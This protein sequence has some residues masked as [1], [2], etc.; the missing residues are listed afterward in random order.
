MGG[1]TYKLFEKMSGIARGTKS[2]LTFPKN[3]AAI[4]TIINKPTYYPDM[5]RK[6]MWEMWKENFV[7]LLKHKELNRFYTSYGLD[8]KEFRDP[9]DFIAHQE[10]CVMRDMGNQAQKHTIT[11]RY[12]YIVLLRDKYA[13][14]SYLASTIG[15]QFIVKSVALIT[16][17]NAFV[18]DTKSWIAPETLLSDGSELVFKVLDG[19]CADGVM[20]VQAKD[21]AVVV[22]GH[23]YTKPEFIQ[24]ISGKNI[25]VQNVVAQHSALKAFKT[26]SVNTIRIVTIKGTSGAVNVFAAFLRLSASPNSFVD[27]RA[28]GG[29]GVGIDLDSGKLM[30]YGFPHDAFG[31]KLEEHPLSHI[32]FEGYQ[33]PYWKETEDLV[34]N[35]HRQFYE[36]QSIGWDVVLTESGPVLLEGNDDWE[37]GGPQDTYGG[38]RKKWNELVMA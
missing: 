22:D 5:E 7:W 15:E 29:L 20:L 33:L 38:L 11:G 36:L 14:S 25:I 34:C 8:I 21:G 28:K 12:N 31:V 17:N 10:F 1:F 9:D 35:A 37:I 6:S 19:E 30:K 26:R 2:F 13:F 32:R 24:S 16:G 3:V 4:G 23:E 27:N 18:A